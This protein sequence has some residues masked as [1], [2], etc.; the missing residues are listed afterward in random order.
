[1]RAVFLVNPASGNGSTGKKW[2][3][4]AARAAE[5]G[6]PGEVLFSERPGHLTEL[7]RSVASPDAFLVVVGGDGTLNEVVNGIVGSGATLAVLP[8]GTGQDFGRTYDIPQKFDA[9]VNVAVNGVT[10]TVDV[11]KVTFTA[12]DGTTQVRHFASMGSVGMSGAVADR[13]NGMSKAL[14]GKATFYY[15]LTR[16][17]LSWRNGEVTTRFEGGERRGLMNNVVVANGKY[18]GGGMMLAPGAVPDD[19]VF[20]IVF[21]GDVSKLDFITTSPK[22][23]GGGHLKHKKVDVVRSPWIEVES[24]RPLPIE[25][26]GEPS[27]TTPVRFEIV[28]AALNV[29]VPA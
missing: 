14:G 4:L 12:A 21:F 2:P 20:D 27:G 17:F 11:G 7:A 29:R 8:N 22:L 6:L 25:L 9:A 13:A 15:A 16:V 1:M 3:K 19:G 18:A 23:Y 5:L 10:R 26:E 28:P 24:T